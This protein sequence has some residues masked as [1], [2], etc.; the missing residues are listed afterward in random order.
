MDLIAQLKDALGE[1]A[2]RTGADIPA[3]NR[4]DAAGEATVRQ[5]AV[6]QRVEQQQAHQTSQ[7]AAA[8]TATTQCD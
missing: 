5:Q 7:S 2:V 4:T 3:R 1:G 6:G 8:T